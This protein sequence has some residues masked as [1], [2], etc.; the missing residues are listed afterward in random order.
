MVGW[1]FKEDWAEANRAAVDGFLRAS[2]AAKA[3]LRDSD[4]EWER[5]R[6]MM[7]AEDEA[8]FVALREGFRAGIPQAGVEQA[9]R[10]ARQAYGVLARE[11]GEAL[12][13]KATELASGVFWRTAAQ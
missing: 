6:P 5:L 12:V 2:D 10:A 13:G 1:V 8:T 3:I 9:E 4:A 7:K 11:G